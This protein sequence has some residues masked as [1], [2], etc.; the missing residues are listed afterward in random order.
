[1]EILR[2]RPPVLYH[3]TTQGIHYSRE[4]FLNPSRHSFKKDEGEPPGAL[5]MA[6]PHETSA[7]LFAVKTRNVSAI[8]HDIPQA[9]II[10]DGYEQPDFSR[11]SGFRY[12][13]PSE[14]FQQ[15]IRQD[16]PTDKW[17]KLAADMEEVSPGKR[18]ISVKNAPR[19]FITMET[20]IKTNEVL[21]YWN[22]RPHYQPKEVY[23]KRIR[24]AINLGRE[25]EFLQEGVEEGWL[26][27]ITD[28]LKRKYTPNLRHAL[29]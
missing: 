21:V 16:K 9:A 10:F 15:V 28:Q 2:E 12:T 25:H 3:G 26:F 24:D 17:Y 19:K 23:K 29:A 18:G 7:D 1:M 8:F 11:L 27:E 13:I 4:P 14:G 22:H 6:T 5:I 20:L